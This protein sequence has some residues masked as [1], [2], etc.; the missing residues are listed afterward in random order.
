MKKTHKHRFSIYY[1]LLWLIFTLSLTLSQAAIWAYSTFHVELAEMMFTIRAPLNGAGGNFVSSAL[2]FCLPK[3][4]AGSLGFGL[5]LLFFQRWNRLSFHVVLNFRSKALRLSSRALEHLTAACVSLGMLAMTC[6]YVQSTYN[7]IGY[8]K[9]NLS[10]TTIYEDYYVTPSDVAIT[11]EEK[12]NLLCIYLEGMEITYSDEDHGGANTQNYIPYL[13]ELALNNTSFGSSD[14]VLGGIQN[15]PNTAWT[16]AALIATTSGIPFNFPMGENDLTYYS[17][18]AENL[19][20]IGQILDENGYYQEFLCGSDATFG[21]RRQ[22]FAQHGNYQIY[23]YS[24]ALEKGAIPPGYKVW[25]GFEDEKLFDIAKNEL[26]RIS[27]QDQP[28]NLTMLTVDTHMTH[29]YICEHCDL[30][31][32]GGEVLPTVLD[33]T[34]RLLENFLDWC[35]EQ[36]FYENTTIV[37]LGD[38]P[39][40]DTDLVDGVPGSVRKV[41]NCFLNTPKAP[42]IP[43]ED[44][45][46]TQLDMF[47][48]ILSSLGFDISGGRLGM[49]TDLFS[50]EPTLIEELGYDYL[51]TELQKQSKFYKENFY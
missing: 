35:K 1:F 37:L 41:Y 29:G 48:T 49:G 28:F 18:F 11:S 4:L 3:I 24:T 22:Y 25:W 12:R 31:K 47:P 34:E 6:A 19:Q 36:P 26:T 44:R 5:L 10:T 38:H 46:L 16:S 13:T 43:T 21:G 40:M 39:R 7:V 2:K 51:S 27:Q 42:A 50:S 45:V 33:C 15:L 30:E 23:D 32:Y 20:T 14:Q 8:V 9:T 17:N